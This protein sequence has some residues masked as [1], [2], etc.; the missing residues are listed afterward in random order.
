MHLIGRWRHDA[1]F[2]QGHAH[3]AAFIKRNV[4]TSGKL[5]VVDHQIPIFVGANHFADL[6]GLNCSG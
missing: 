6:L 5:R 3:H 4:S 1:L 2:G